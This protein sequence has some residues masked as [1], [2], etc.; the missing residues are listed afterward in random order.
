[1]LSGSQSVNGQLCGQKNAGKDKKDK[2]RYR[3]TV[4]GAAGVGKSAIISQ[5]LYDRFQEEYNQT[6]E[7]LHQGDFD[8]NGMKLTLDILD[9]AGAYSFPAMRQLAISTSD[10]FVLVYSVADES[11]FQAVTELREQI[12]K[13]KNSD[14][15]PIVIVANK[16]DV[17][18]SNRALERVTA[19]S[20][21]C[22]EWGNGYVEASAKDNV[23]IVGIF[24]EI[25][26][27]SKVQYALSPAVR[28]RRQSTPA[29]LP[30]KKKVQSRQTRTQRQSC[31]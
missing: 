7:E 14:D 19:E 29:A 31:S 18:D 12:L 21:V 27:Q 2:S 13:E 30:Q 10:A 1:M 28:R 6:V 15:V 25:L 22:V 26:R 24:K 16:V 8:F 4:M 9:T 20:I 23:N 17:G 11:S 3:I 5:F